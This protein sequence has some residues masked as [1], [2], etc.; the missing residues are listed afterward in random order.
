MKSNPW[1]GNVSPWK[2]KPEGLNVSELNSKPNCG[3]VS[4]CGS[5]PCYSN[6]SIDKNKSLERIV[7]KPLSNSMWKDCSYEHDY[8][9]WLKCVCGNKQ[10]LVL[11]CIGIVKQSYS[12]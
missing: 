2:N 12:I 4:N 1:R 7:T 8:P 10:T 5:N 3:N 11:K 6:V 9:S